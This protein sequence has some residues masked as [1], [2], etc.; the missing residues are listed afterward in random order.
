MPLIT[1]SRESSSPWAISPND[2][3]KELM[4]FVTPLRNT[5]AARSML[6]GAKDRSDDLATQRTLCG[7]RVMA[8]SEADGR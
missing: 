2:F 8:L 1:A 5:S 4:K 6:H 3:I 7:E